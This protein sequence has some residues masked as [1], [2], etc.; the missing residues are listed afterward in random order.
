MTSDKGGAAAAA[1]RLHEG[2]LQ[3]GQDSALLVLQKSSSVE[4]CYPVK[5]P[6]YKRWLFRLKNK[7]QFTRYKETLHANKYFFRLHENLYSLSTNDILKSL[8]FVPD[9]FVV[10][11]ITGF[12]DFKQ[13][14][15]LQIVTGARMVFNHLDMSLFTGGCHYSFGCRGY[16]VDCVACPAIKNSAI[17][18]SAAIQLKERQKYFPK[19]SMSIVPST[20]LDE[21]TAKSVLF[22]K[23]LSRKILIGLDSTTYLPRDKSGLREK[24]GMP[25]LKRVLL[26][27]AETV[28]D[29]RKGFAYLKKALEELSS[30]IPTDKKSKILLVVI[31]KSSSGQGVFDGIDF[32]CV[33]V[34]YANTSAQLI[35]Y[36]QLSDF[37]VCPSVEDSGPMMI[38]EAM[39]CGLPVLAFD[40]GVARDLITQQT[41]CIAELKN[42]HELSAAI[43]RFALMPDDELVAFQEASR[44][45]ALQ[46]ITIENQLREF[47]ILLSEEINGRVAFPY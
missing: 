9:I 4:R 24:Y 3:S 15:K 26:F 32:E 43:G 34:P 30:V 35:E 22:A 41:G 8:P 14:Y 18:N 25:Q 11:W 29:E 44:N 2:L 6:A 31:G 46:C 21:Q 20:L 5:I 47:K 45:N 7:I 19:N 16:E 33:V 38:N 1:I 10:H 28:D 17:R 23:T 37:F 40:N 13:L 12:M 39:M 42:V 27:G 36:Y